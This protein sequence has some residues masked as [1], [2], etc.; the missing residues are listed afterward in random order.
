MGLVRP[1]PDGP[2]WKFAL[3]MLVFMGSI[4]VSVWLSSPVPAAFSVLGIIMF[5]EARG[6]R[7]PQCRRRLKQ[8]KV[9]VEGGPTYRVFWECS[10]CIALWDGERLVDP[11][12]DWC[13]GIHSPDVH[14]PA[15]PLCRGPLYFCIF[16]EIRNHFAFLR[17]PL[18]LS[19]L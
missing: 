9:P 8:R 3:G 10:R 15:Y 12:R 16:I 1:L 2:W 11:T 19:L 4:V 6:L 7:C 14:S 17:N 18:N 5:V 13:R